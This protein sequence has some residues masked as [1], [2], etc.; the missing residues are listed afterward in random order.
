MTVSKRILVAGIGNAWL[1]DDGFGGTVVQRLNESELPPEAAIFDFGTGGLEL[2]YE[3]MRGYDALILVDVSKQGGEPGTLYV[4]E[5]P[6]D[7]VPGEVQ[8]GDAINPHAMS[9][10]S[11]LRFVKLFGGWPGKVLV[12]GC[13][14]DDVEEVSLD[15]SPAVAGAID[16]AVD[17]VRRTIE[18]LRHDAAYAE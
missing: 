3:V 2:A 7:S 17:L 9:P 6:E 10:E 13:E 18:E 1:S 12:I 8:D 4:M 14:P 11:V 5:I 15:L 16:G